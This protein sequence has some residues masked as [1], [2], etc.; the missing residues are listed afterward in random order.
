M[1]KGKSPD[2]TRAEDYYYN[3]VWSEEDGAFIGRVA[4]F[5]SLAAHA[6]TLDGAL[7]EIK[8]V[9]TF[10]L[11]DL[12]ESREPIPEPFSKRAYSGKLNLRM[13]E[14]LHR[15]LVME[16]ARQGVSL[17]QWINLKLEGGR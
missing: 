12:S 1:N 5:P 15:Q 14:T 8:K 17:N 3:V 13:P 16:A 9:V 4:E 11:K 2:K 10:V 7:R 6:R